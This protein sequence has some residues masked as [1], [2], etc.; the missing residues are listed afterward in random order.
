MG[1]SMHLVIRSL[2]VAA[3]VSTICG[4]ARPAGAAEPV[5][6]VEDVQGPVKDVQPFDY[7]TTGTRLQV[8][9][10]ATLVLGYL[11]SCARET[12][13]G[14]KIVIGTEQSAIDGGQVKRE[15]VECDGGR[16]Q[17]TAS[18]ASKSGVMVFRGAPKPTSAPA[19]GPQPQL[20]VYGMSPI[21]TLAATGRLEVKRLD[22][23]GQPPLDF[24]ATK[25][26][27]ARTAVVDLARQ[28]VALA[29][30]GIYQA[31]SGAQSVV[32]KVD[33]LAKP[34]AVPAVGRLVRLP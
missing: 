7:L 27:G 6:I 22:A 33:P 8:P 25:P 21:F 26:A 29:P 28:D 19:G 18:Q 15:R 11:K 14:A 10:Q 5:A 12:I 16:M 4:A 17:L 2:L 9:P 34:G 20:T 24:A 31:S 1:S 3:A 32:F 13:T 23:T 30:G